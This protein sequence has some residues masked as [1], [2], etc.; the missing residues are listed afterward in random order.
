MKYSPPLDIE[1]CDTEGMRNDNI[2]DKLFSYDILK[3]KLYSKRKGK[4]KAITLQAWTGREGSRRLR[5]PDF[6]TFGT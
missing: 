5:L 2:V 1:Q 3:S 4:G 6:K